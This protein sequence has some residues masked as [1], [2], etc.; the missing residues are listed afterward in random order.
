VISGKS[1]P[2]TIKRYIFFQIPE[3]LLTIVAAYIVKYFIDYPAWIAYTIIA[4]SILKDFILYHFI[5]PSYIPHKKDDIS[6]MT[7]KECIAVEDFS[8]W[9]KVRFQ[10]ELWRAHS[11]SPVKK[12]DRLIIQKIKGL[13]LFVDKLNPDS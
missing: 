4:G 2:A 5:W 13:N 12:G 6:K 1:D 3:L 9:G 10:G 8:E 7:G 11:K